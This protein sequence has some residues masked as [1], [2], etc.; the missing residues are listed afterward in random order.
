[1]AAAEDLGIEK[2]EKTTTISMKIERKV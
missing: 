2:R 1:M